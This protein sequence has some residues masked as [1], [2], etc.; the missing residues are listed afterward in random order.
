M[1]M[2]WL[3]WVVANLWTYHVAEFQPGDAEFKWYDTGRFYTNP[4]YLMALASFLQSLSHIVEDLPP[5]VS[6]KNNT[7]VVC[8]HILLCCTVIVALPSPMCT[9]AYPHWTTKREFFCG[10]VDSWCEFADRSARGFFQ[11]CFGA[12]DEF[13]ASPRLIPLF[14]GIVPVYWCM[15]KCGCRGRTRAHLDNLYGLGKKSLVCGRRSLCIWM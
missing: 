3:Q 9:A 5:R 12:V 7:M 15:R 8:P 13:I 1:Q 4:L 2:N 10:T 6:G 14:W 11:F